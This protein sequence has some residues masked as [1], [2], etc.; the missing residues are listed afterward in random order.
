MKT[1]GK[2]SFNFGVSVVNAG[3]RQVT[4]EPQLIFTSTPGGIRITGPVSKALGVQHGENVMFVNNVAMID[5]AIIAKEPS[6]VAFCEENGLDINDPETVKIIHKVGDQWWIAKGYQIFDKKG[7]PKMTKERLSK[8][9]RMKFVEANFDTMLE[10]ARNSGDAELAKFL[11]REGIT[12]EEIKDTLCKYVTNNEVPMYAGSKTANPAKLTGLG[13]NL[14]F[15]DSAIWSQI[16]EDLGHDGDKVNRVFTLDL[17][18]AIKERVNNGYEEIEVLMIPFI[19][20][21][22]GEY[23]DEKPA[24]I[25]KNSEAEAA[26]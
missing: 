1:F 25:S 6:I 15:T 19:G 23:K 13:V 22:C 12:E 2:M 11:N 18:K 16:K 21:D 14:N 3:Q 24:R 9:E 5:Q 17:D 8:D 7:N 4:V 20:E 10:G 26:E